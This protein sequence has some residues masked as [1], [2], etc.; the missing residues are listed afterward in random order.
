MTKN[1][2]RV[3]QWESEK[4]VMRGVGSYDPPERK[5]ATAKDAETG[6]TIIPVMR[7]I[8]QADRGISGTVGVKIGSRSTSTPRKIAMG[9]YRGGKKLHDMLDLD[10]GGL[11]ALTPGPLHRRIQGAINM[12][13]ESIDAAI[14]RKPA[15]RASHIGKTIHD[16]TGHGGKS[17]QVR[18]PGRHR[19]R[20]IDSISPPATCRS[21]ILGTEAETATRDATNSVIYEVRSG[22]I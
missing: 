17:L 10:D 15:A 16:M 12:T 14:E 18:A 4:G 8:S 1:I 7:A 9:P 20:G 21:L 19:R 13:P 22:K 3:A 2:R 6:D 5:I 11:R